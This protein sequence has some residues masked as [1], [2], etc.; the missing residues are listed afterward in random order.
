MSYAIDAHVHTINSDGQ[1]DALHVLDIAK[2]AGVSTVV[3][4]DHSGVTYSE[5]IQA[6]AQNIGINMPLM[7]IEVST[8][9][10]GHKYHVLAYAKSLKN[11]QLERYLMYPTMVKNDRFVK[12][13]SGLIENGVQIPGKTDILKGIQEDGKYSHPDKWMYT[14]TLIASYVSKALGIPLE[15]A[16][17]LFADVGTP[18]KRIVAVEERLSREQKYLSTTEVIRNLAQYGAV[19]IIAHPWWECTKTSDV[20]TVIRHFGAFKEAGVSGFEFEYYNNNPVFIA[21]SENLASFYPEFIH[22]GGSDFHG[23][24]RFDI[25][26]RGVKQEDFEQLM[27]MV[28]A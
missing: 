5:S 1:Y 15:E 24:K 22:V 4:T 27:K 26:K 8:I 13:I 23:D 18:D 21:A 6:Y 7:G 20:E 3:F 10:E 19:S 2:R 17:A 14:G 28:R 16:R 25:G 9:H 11:E 12:I